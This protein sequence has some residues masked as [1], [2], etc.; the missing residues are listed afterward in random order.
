MSESIWE[1]SNLV[2]DPRVER[3]CKHELRDSRSLARL[4]VLN[5]KGALLVLPHEPLVRFRL[6]ERRSRVA[7]V[8]LQGE[9]D[10]GGS[11]ARFDCLLA[12]SPAEPRGLKDQQSVAGQVLGPRMRFH[13]E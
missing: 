1:C 2:R 12:Q 13:V 11:A 7:G 6:A 8:G 4:S 5:G 9:C 10:P 3:T